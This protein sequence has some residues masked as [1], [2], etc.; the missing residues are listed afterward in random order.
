MFPCWHTDAQLHDSSW[1]NAPL[2]HNEKGMK[3]QV[4]ILRP[5]LHV[6][7][8]SPQ[9]LITN[10]PFKRCISAYLKL[11]FE[12]A[13]HHIVCGG[14]FWV[15][16]DS[17]PWQLCHFV[18]I[19]WNDQYFLLSK[20]SVI[21]N[22]V[23]ELCELKWNVDHLDRYKVIQNIKRYKSN[24]RKLQMYQ[25]STIMAHT[26]SFLTSFVGNYSIILV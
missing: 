14:L 2:F 8:S 9:Q 12:F 19:Y 17:F 6:K 22:N 24:S 21:I 10:G 3:Q 15:H 20:C 7:A 1:S 11:F 13:V 5:L 16:C 18:A 25:K 23:S 26:Q 4:A